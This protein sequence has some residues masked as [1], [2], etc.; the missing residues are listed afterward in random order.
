MTDPTVEKAVG[1]L[2]F[3]TDRADF[4]DD[5]M[6]PYVEATDDPANPGQKI[7]YTNG[8]FLQWRAGQL[9]HPAPSGAPIGQPVSP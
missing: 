1:R 5:K 6:R 9:Q 7:K 4:G 2:A 8:M 3:F